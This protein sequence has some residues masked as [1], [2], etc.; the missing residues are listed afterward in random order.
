MV[1]FGVS[2][3]TIKEYDDAIFIED[4]FPV[5]I[6]H[7]KTTTQNVSSSDLSK[8]DCS[9]MIELKKK[10]KQETKIQKNFESDFSTY[11][12]KEDPQTCNEAITFSA[13]FGKKPLEVKWILY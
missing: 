3:N 5:K 6:K 2:T 9:E 11:L 12:V 10:K 13:S 4:V 7:E 1:N 8:R